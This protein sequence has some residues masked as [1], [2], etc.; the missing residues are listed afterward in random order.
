MTYIDLLI[1]TLPTISF[2]LQSDHPV[3]GPDGAVRSGIFHVP[4]AGLNASASEPGIAAC[5][6]LGRQL[7]EARPSRSSLPRGLIESIPDARLV[8]EMITLYFETTQS[9][10]HILDSRLFSDQYSKNRANIRRAPAWFVLQLVLVL[11]IAGPMHTKSTTR[12]FVAQN[13]HHWIHT[14]HTWLS[15]PLEKDRLTLEW[16]QVHCLILLARMVCGSGADL[17]WISTGSLVRMAVQ[18]G[19]SQDPD[20][21]KGIHDQDF[22][23]KNLRR[24]LWFSILEI[25]LQASIDS[26]MMPAREKYT[27]CLPLP[28]CDNLEQA[29]KACPST[30][31]PDSRLKNIS[32]RVEQTEHF[33]GSDVSPEMP[34]FG[35]SLRNGAESTASGNQEE[36]PTYNQSS[37]QEVLAASLSARSSALEAIY[38]LQ[39]EPNHEEIL[40]VDNELIQT[41]SKVRATMDRKVSQFGEDALIQFGYNLCSHIFLRSRLCL[42]FPFAMSAPNNH[43]FAHSHKICLEVALELITLLEDDRYNLLMIRGGGMFRDI[44]TRGGVMIFAEL[45]P[46]LAPEVSLVRKN[47]ARQQSL[48]RDAERVVKYAKDRIISGEIGVK[49]YV[50]FNIMMARCEARLEGKCVDNVAAQISK[51]SLDLCRSMLENRVANLQSHDSFMAPMMSA[52][53][54]DHELEL[55]LFDFDHL[56]NEEVMQSWDLMSD[57]RSIC[58]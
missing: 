7:K 15:G 48:W 23:T 34:L 36:Y 45:Y 17:V 14:A 6:R 27:T 29:S 12:E 43:L 58:Q 55:G 11:S 26:G 41:W 21:L 4:N 57:W 16:I 1:D 20:Y 52:N 37:F 2:Q 51:E 35:P 19:L 30:P 5:K 13:S 9:C 18:M 3:L 46:K 33:A 39:E 25:D 31:A 28:P 38:K 56:L 24:H 44:L 53:E 50:F 10:F 40:R 47:R 32:R 42:H 54:A 49:G 22:A 8:D